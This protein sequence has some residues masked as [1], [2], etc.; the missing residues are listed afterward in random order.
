M[1]NIVS[2]D[3]DSGRR[4]P[5]P[6]A[7]E[8]VAILPDNRV[9]DF[10]LSRFPISISGSV[11]IFCIRYNQL[12]TRRC[13]S[14]R[15]V[16]ISI[17]KKVTDSQKWPKRALKQFFFKISG[18]FQDFFPRFLTNFY[19]SDRDETCCVS[20]KHHSL[21]HFFGIFIQR[22]RQRSPTPR[23]PIFSSPNF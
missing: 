19:L 4:P 23:P 21:G 8:R 14:L 7:A 2:S 16:E 13:Y 22:P 20:S 11:L 3:R 17:R 1:N 10:S 15:N 12:K 18:F 6:K 9:L 5:T